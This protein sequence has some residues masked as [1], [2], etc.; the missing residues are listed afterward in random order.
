MTQMGLEQR[1]VEKV[2]A[3]ELELAHQQNASQRK[4]L[5]WMPSP[6]VPERAER[7]ERSPEL[8]EPDLDE[9]TTDDLEEED[10]AFSDHGSAS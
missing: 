4:H 3:Q 7:R 5:G 6:G 10:V 9:P 8:G 1:R 2:R